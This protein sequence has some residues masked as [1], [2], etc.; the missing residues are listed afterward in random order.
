VTV[1]IIPRDDAEA[2]VWA[3]ALEVAALFVDVPWVLVG[4]QMV[5][6]L[7]HEAGRVSGRT[8]GDVDAVVDVRALTGGARAA[9]ERLVSAGYQPASAEHP[10]RFISGTASVDLLA[11]DHL[12]RHADL[13]TIPPAT[14]TAIPG[15]SRALA[16]RRTIEVDI[17]GVGAGAL[18]LP[19]LPGAIALKVRAWH[20]RHAPRDAEDLVRLL[21]LVTDVEAVRGELKPGERRGLAQ[22]APLTNAGDRAWRAVLDPDDAQAAFARLAE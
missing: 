2:R 11:P 13:T 3:T 14:T 22:V 17:I 1:A 19:S 4:A 16:T 15:G 10:C 7:E 18:P 9:A 20:A 6:L 21:S 8:T 5:M 12:G